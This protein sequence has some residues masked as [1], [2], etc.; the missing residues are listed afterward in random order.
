[1][2]LNDNADELYRED[3]KVNVYM[4][5]RQMH[6]IQYVA[7]KGDFVRE[8]SPGVLQIRILRPKKEKQNEHL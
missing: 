4:A 1:M 7:S 3:T 8:E 6:Y 2:A 5:E